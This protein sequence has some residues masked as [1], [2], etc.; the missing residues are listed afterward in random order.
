[1]LIGGCDGRMQNGALIKMK[2]LSSSSLLRI[3]WGMVATTGQGT[4]KLFYADC[5]ADKATSPELKRKGQHLQCK[6]CGA[7]THRHSLDQE[8]VLRLYARLPPPSVEDF[9]SLATTMSS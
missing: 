9:K 8:K 1:M 3:I 7:S 5:L 4:Q 2:D 6:E